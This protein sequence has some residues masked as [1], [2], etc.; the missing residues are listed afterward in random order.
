MILGCEYCLYSCD[1]YAEG[2]DID[3]N[4]VVVYMVALIKI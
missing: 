4:D 3:A 2:K 1:V